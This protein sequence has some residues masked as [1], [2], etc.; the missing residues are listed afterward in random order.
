MKCLKT[1]S[2]F[3]GQL[4]PFSCVLFQCAQENCCNQLYFGRSRHT[5]C[6]HPKGETDSRITCVVVIQVFEIAPLDSLGNTKLHLQIFI[7]SGYY[8]KK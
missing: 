3:S 8:F 5:H 7:W 4:Q 1:S 2:T 6:A